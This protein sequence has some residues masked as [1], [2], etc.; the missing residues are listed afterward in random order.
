[1]E[2]H[3]RVC[4][5]LYYLGDPIIKG[6]RVMLQ[7]TGLSRHRFSLSKVR[8]LIFSAMCFFYVGFRFIYTGVIAVHP[9]LIYCPMLSNNIL[10]IHE[11]MY[12]IYRGY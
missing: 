6:W 3:L 11:S 9:C 5:Y 1:M 8:T 10:N 12:Y 7:L 2:A 4:L